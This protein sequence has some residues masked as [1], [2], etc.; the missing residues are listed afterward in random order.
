MLAVHAEVSEIEIPGSNGG[1]GTVPLHLAIQS[2]GDHVD[3]RCYY[4][5]PLVPTNDVLCH[6]F[7]TFNGLLG[8]YIFVAYVC[9]GKAYNELRRKCGLKEVKQS[10]TGSRATS[11]TESMTS[12]G[13]KRGK[14]SKGD[15]STTNGNRTLDTSVGNSMKGH[16]NRVSV[17]V[18]NGTKKLPHETSV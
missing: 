2:H 9:T 12:R 13:S 18:T 14:Y 8:L 15:S 11:R 6:L 1:A 17:E 3:L 7:V 5:A 16:S 10:S 4:V